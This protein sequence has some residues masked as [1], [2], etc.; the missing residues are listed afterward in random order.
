MEMFSEYYGNQINEKI[1]EV[2]NE[3]GNA[4]NI[5]SVEEDLDRRC[6]IVTLYMDIIEDEDEEIKY[7]KSLLSSFKSIMQSYRQN[8]FRRYEYDGYG[9]VTMFVK[10]EN[11]VK[12][13]FYLG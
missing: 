9:T 5:I 7:H 6:V 1:Y 3:D 11:T 2:F 13:Y 12:K 4:D 8:P 10:A